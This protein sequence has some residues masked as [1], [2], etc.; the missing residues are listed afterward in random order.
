MDIEYS[1]DW[2]GKA[3]MLH[4]NLNLLNNIV[5]MLTMNLFFLF[6]DKWKRLFDF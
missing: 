6:L 1:D 2:M 4:K 3:E 5:L